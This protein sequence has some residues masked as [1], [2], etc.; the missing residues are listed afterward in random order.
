MQVNAYDNPNEIFMNTNP[1]EN[2][3]LECND[4]LNFT[5]GVESFTTG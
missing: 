1:E 3:L 5:K 4:L 2:Y